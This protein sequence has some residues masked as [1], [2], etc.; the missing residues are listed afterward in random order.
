MFCSNC[1]KKIQ[2]TAKFCKYCSAA[3]S[4]NEEPE[5][6]VASSVCEEVQKTVHS[7]ADKEPEKAVH[8]SVGEEAT[9]TAD[10]K[11]RIV[12]TCIIIGVILL[13]MLIGILASTNCES[14]LTSNVWYE[15]T[16]GK[17]DFGRVLTFNEDGTCYYKL[18]L[19]AN[20]LYDAYT[21][22]W[23]VLDDDVLAFKDEY[24]PY[25]PDGGDGWYVTGDELYIDG[26]IFY[27]ED[28]YNF[29]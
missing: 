4:D 8:S 19:G 5:K 18:Y 15:K 12:T 23:A 13:I 22:D 24:Y 9:A 3:V 1:G 29:Y 21:T 26:H 14:R 11:R 6:T 20:S 25:D 28:K 16:T 10:D 2:D 7:S 17:N 27:D